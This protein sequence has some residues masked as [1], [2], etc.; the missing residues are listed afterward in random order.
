ASNVPM[1]ATPLISPCGITPASVTPKC[2]GWSVVSDNRRYASIINGTLDAFTEIFTSSKSTSR[3]RS[4]SCIAEATI[5]SGVI[6]PWRPAWGARLGR[7]ER[8]GV[9]PDGDRSAAR[10]GLGRPQLDGLGLGVVA[11]VQAQRVHTR[12]ECAE[13]EL[14]LEVDVG[15]D[16][17]RRARNDLREA[18]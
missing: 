8:S 7:M 6:P 5:A 17:D 12:L 16:R 9:P 18:L 3:N 2:S 4:S 15:D 1:P 13:R 11:G 14:V 10:L